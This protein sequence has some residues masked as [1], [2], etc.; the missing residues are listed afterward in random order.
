MGRWRRDTALPG[1]F[2]DLL[3][4]KAHKATQV[5]PARKDRKAYK[6]IQDSPAHRVRKATQVLPDRKACKAM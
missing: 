1:D 2:A 5:P 3:D 6:V 4:R